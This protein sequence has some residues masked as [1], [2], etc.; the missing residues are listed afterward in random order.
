L[1]L[2][3]SSAIILV[4]KRLREN[5]AKILYGKGTLNL[6]YYEIGN[7]IWKQYAL[8]GLISLEEAVARASD[9]TQILEMMQIKEVKSSE[10]YSKAMK[11]AMEQKITFYDASY[12]QV[13]KEN[14]YTLITED[15][16]LL[17]KSRNINVKAITV[18]DFLSSPLY[19]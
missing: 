12:L 4:L 14:G 3:D 13:A 11:I 7:A 19:K 15:R 1:Y 18:N 9:V 16:K 17:E 2:L 8:E 10:C 6:A 5:A